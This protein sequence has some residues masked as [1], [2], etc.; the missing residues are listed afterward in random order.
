MNY[1]DLLM[2]YF[3]SIGFCRILGRDSLL[4]PRGLPGHTKTITKTPLGLSSPKNGVLGI[5]WNY[6]ELLWIYYEF[7]NNS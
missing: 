1:N 5:I 2:N 7:D 6:I 4:G 3:D